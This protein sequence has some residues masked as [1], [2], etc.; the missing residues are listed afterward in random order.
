MNSKPNLHE[1]VQRL[2]Q[3]RERYEKYL[4]GRPRFQSMDSISHYLTDF[5]HTKFDEIEVFGQ[6]T[7]VGVLSAF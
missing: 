1:Y 6:Y 5:Q 7:E 4:D 3:W 2:L